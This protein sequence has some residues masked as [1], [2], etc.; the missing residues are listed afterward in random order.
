MPYLNQMHAMLAYRYEKWSNLLSRTLATLGFD[1][2]FSGTVYQGWNVWIQIFF[3]SQFLE[4]M[5]TIH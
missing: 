4:P 5:N 2:P 1:T 3:R